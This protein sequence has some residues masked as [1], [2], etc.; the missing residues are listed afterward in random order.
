[1]AEQIIRGSN[2]A[3]IGSIETQ[4]NGVQ[5][6]RGSSGAKVGDYDPKT[7]ITRGQNGAKIGDGNLLAAL[8]R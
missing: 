6:A 4:S 1:M 3:K 5:V 8:I 7:N 2:G